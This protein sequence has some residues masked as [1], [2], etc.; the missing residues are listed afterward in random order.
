M[1]V[2]LGKRQ[3]TAPRGMSD[4]KDCWDLGVTLVCI[5]A[6]PHL[7]VQVQCRVMWVGNSV[8]FPFPQCHGW[9]LPLGD[10]WKDQ[11]SDSEW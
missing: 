5:S 9:L 6:Q 4:P 1:G 11:Y 10:P 7:W 8:G 2:R 3:E